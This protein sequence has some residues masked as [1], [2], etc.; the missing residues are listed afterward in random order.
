MIKSHLPYKLYMCP[1]IAIIFLLT[2][3]GAGYV[4]SEQSLGTNDSRALALGDVDGDDDLDMV[5]AN[6]NQGN[7]V[8]LNDSAGNYSDA[9]LSL[10]TNS[11]QSIVLGDIDG[12]DDLDMVVANQNQANLVYFNDGAGSFSDSEI[13]RASCRERV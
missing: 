5:A 10:G 2:G 6:Q 7:K 4:D 3:C 13:G 9:T 12:D 1:A 11:S 8:Y